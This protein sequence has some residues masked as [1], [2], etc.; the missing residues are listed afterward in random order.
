MRL[1]VNTTLRRV[2]LTAQKDILTPQAQPVT[3]SVQNSQ[4]IAFVVSGPTHNWR[5]P[6]LFDH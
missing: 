2:F 4:D 5:H 3:L 6:M 1:D